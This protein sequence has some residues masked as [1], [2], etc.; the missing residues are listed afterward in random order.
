[1]ADCISAS[2]GVM[3]PRFL[4]EPNLGN[5]WDVMD[6]DEPWL[7]REVLLESIL[8][9]VFLPGVPVKEVRLLEGVMARYVSST[10]PLSYTTMSN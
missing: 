1:V 10:S 8:R 6:W 2:V 4:S 7:E 5:P 9:L 3:D